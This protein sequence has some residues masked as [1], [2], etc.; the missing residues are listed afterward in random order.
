[1][2]LSF[3]ISADLS[4]LEWIIYLEEFYKRLINDWNGPPD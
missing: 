4:P 1:M 2:A 3:C